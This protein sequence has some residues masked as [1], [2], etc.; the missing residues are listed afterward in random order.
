MNDKKIL[1]TKLFAVNSSESSGDFYNKSYMPHYPTI[2]TAREEKQSRRMVGSNFFLF[3]SFVFQKIIKNKQ[4][5]QF[6]LRHIFRKKE[7]N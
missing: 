3:F 5:T 2:P 7:K 4:R 6:N 1:I